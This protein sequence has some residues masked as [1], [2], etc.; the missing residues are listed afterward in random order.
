MTPLEAMQR[1]LNGERLTGFSM[2][3]PPPVASTIGFEPTAI[4][5]GGATFRMD[6]RVERHG[7]P[8]GTI[9][10]GVLC[11]LA[12]A[13][14][15][16]ACASLLIDGESFT[17]L[18]LKINYLRPVW[19]AT[20]EARATAVHSGKSMAYLECEVVKLP[21]EKLV[22]KATSTCMILRGNLAKGR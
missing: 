13:A 6:A 11:D 7:N 2:A 14:M 12:D 19:D 15:G 17:T 9:H 3:L 22:A 8:M 4:E 10:G 21:E 16:M 5:K 18:E 1:V 20:L